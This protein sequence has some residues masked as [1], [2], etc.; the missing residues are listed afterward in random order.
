MIQPRKNLSR[1]IQAMHRLESVHGLKRQLVVVGKQG[2]KND[3][4]FSVIDQAGM[5][6]RITFTGFVPDEDLVHL[7]RRCEVFAYPSLY[8][9]FGLPVVEAMAAGAPVLTSDC[10]SLREVAGNAAELCD[11][12]S[13]ESIAGRLAA[14]IRAPAWRGQ[15]IERGFR[16]A[17]AFSWDETARRTLAAYTDALNERG[18][19]G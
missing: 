6:D 9:G 8:E 13:V 14:L 16:Q 18:R 10:S 1:L 3:E 11:P 12:E 4:L 5:A 15:L 2:W 7:Y 19:M 17:R